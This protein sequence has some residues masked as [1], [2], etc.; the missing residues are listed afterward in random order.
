MADYSCAP[1]IIPPPVEPNDPAIQNDGWFP[2]VDM[3]KLRKSLRLADA[4]SPEQLRNAA[5]AAIV[6]I[7]VNLEQW[8]QAQL[9]A[10]YAAL[11]DVPA[12]DLD[13]ESRLLFL[14]RR[15]VSAAARAEL[16]ERRRDVDLTGAGQRKVDEL[17]SS[18]GE[19]RR[20]AIHAMRDIMG[21][22]R[23]AVELI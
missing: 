18:I 11:A 2:P 22:T 4:V 23:T 14:Y 21:R 3:L 20:D 12:P 15:A 10:G 7:A 9:A 5:L 1:S 17:D 19:L 16:A 6:W 13:G 8:K